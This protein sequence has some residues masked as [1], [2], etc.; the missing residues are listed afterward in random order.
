[1]GIADSIPSRGSEIYLRFVR[2][3]LPWDDP[4]SEAYYTSTNKIQQKETS[5]QHWMKWTTTALWGSTDRPT[6][7]PG[8]LKV[9]ESYVAASGPKFREFWL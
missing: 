9:T 1:M 8:H 3:Y 5:K 6:Y 4:P 7:K 2:F